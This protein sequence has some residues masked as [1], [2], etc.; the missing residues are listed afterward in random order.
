MNVRINT[1]DLSDRAFA[2]KLN[3]KAAELLSIA[4]EDFTA[5]IEAVNKKI[6]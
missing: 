4:K 1:K 6:V 2:D 5:I 3:A